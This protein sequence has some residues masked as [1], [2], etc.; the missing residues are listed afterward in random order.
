MMNPKKL[1]GKVERW[2]ELVQDHV[3]CRALILKVLNL[4]IL[5]P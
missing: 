3:Q 4:H 5:I 1:S 2:M